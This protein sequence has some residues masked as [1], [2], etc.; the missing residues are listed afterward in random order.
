MAMEGK[1]TND[2]RGMEPADLFR[3][4]WIT[5]PQLAPDGAQA[6]FVVTMLDEEADDYR[7]AI[8]TV[9][10]EGAEPRRFT[11]GPR[12]DSSPRWSPDGRSLAFISER[13]GEKGQL[14]VIPAT[15]GEAK[16]LTSEK[17]GVGSPVWSPDSRHVCVTAKISTQEEPSDSAASTPQKESK[18]A[19]PARVI[20]TLKYR[21]NGEGFTYD[22][23]R[24]LLLVTVDT[25][26]CRWLADGDFNDDQAAWSPDGRTM[27]F[28]SARHEARDYDRVSDLFSVTIDGGTVERLTDGGFN[29]EAPV[30]SPDGS[31]I[32]FL[33]HRGPD[34]GPRH[35]RL[36]LLPLG[37][38][39]LCLTTDLD[40]NLSSSPDLRWSEDGGRIFFTADVHGNRHLLAIDVTSGAIETVLGGE[41][42]ISAVSMDRGRK[43]IA[44]TASNSAEPAD[45]FVAGIDGQGERRIGG[46][47]RD[48]LADVSLPGA[49]RIGVT[50]PDGTP[51]DAWFIRPANYREGVAH[52]VLLNIHG[53]PFAQQGNSFSDEF[54]VQV[55]AG[56]GVLYCN[57]RGSSGYGEEFARAILGEPGIKD[58]DDVLASLDH[59]LATAADID[60]GRL[61]ILGGSYGGYLTSWIIGHTDRFA[62]ACSE[63][64]INN[65]LSK[66]GTDDVNTTWTYFRTEPQHNPE[67]FLRLS[68]LMYADAMVTPVLILHS[69]EDLRCPMEQA[70]QLYTALKRL[71]RDVV[72]VRFPGEN[73]ELS[74]SGKPSHRIQ[75][76]ELQVDFFKSRMKVAEPAESAPAPVAA[77]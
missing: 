27:V 65:R 16:K 21:Y 45:L 66:A 62:A 12:R 75:R 60:S 49:Q 67:L 13:D 58:T 15:G 47:N 23:R 41:R 69:E 39:P 37:G 71:R 43:L 34:D 48:W 18:K 63:R 40:L 14:F 74:R 29:V 2:R 77:R 7:S 53:G 24:H 9:P 46:L 6:A 19:P 42:S 8:W 31:T 36:W 28:V 56:F 59:L 61:G 64:A 11:F 76:F 70:E 5:D 3:V 26:E 10:L 20:T 25:S 32:A 33:G 51:I 35:S 38:E 57:F 1:V 30:G 50:S 54:Q 52:P 68:P 44:Y 4:R 17:L 73:H 22:K 55:G 72:F